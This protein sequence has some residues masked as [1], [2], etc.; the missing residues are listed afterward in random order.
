ML[1]YKACRKSIVTLELLDDS[2]NNEKRDGVID[3]N[4]AKFRCDKA[5]VISITEVKT[6]EKIEKDISIFHHKFEYKLGKIVKA[7]NF[8]FDLDIVCSEGIHYFKTKEAALSWFYSY[9]DDGKISWYENGQKKFEGTY[10]NEKKN[11]TWIKYYENGQKRR[12]GTYINGKK[13]GKWI[14]YFVDGEKNFEG[15]FKD[16]NRDGKW[17][18]WWPNSQK[19]S[20]GTWKDGKL[21]GKWIDLDMNGEKETEEIY[22]DG[23]RVEMIY[24]KW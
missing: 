11:G 4:Y 23:K 15:V 16:G 18:Y 22:K 5:K 13:Y 21:D 14:G 20:E 12:E 10:I 8:N 7:F 2:I 9:P 24:C 1:R 19:H 6:G 3:K 17:I